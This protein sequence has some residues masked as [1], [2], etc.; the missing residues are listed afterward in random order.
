MAPI[1]LKAVVGE[2]KWSRGPPFSILPLGAAEPRGMPSLPIAPPGPGWVQAGRIPV[3]LCRGVAL[4]LGSQSCIMTPPCT[5]PFLNPLCPFPSTP[6][7]APQFAPLQI[8]TLPA[9]HPSA[10]PP[11]CTPS[12]PPS[13]HPCLSPLPAPPPLPIISPLLGRPFSPTPSQALPGTPTSPSPLPP[14][15]L[16]HRRPPPCTHISSPLSPS[17]PS[18]FPGLPPTLSAL[19]PSLDPPSLSAAPTPKY[20]GNRDRHPPSPG[21][22]PWGARGRAAGLRG[23]RGAETRLRRS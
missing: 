4:S 23:C 6:H 2:S 18:L 9:P 12:L 14:I 13:P 16:L 10:T 22:F 17:L 3:R 19:F 21:C 5:P 15:S 20:L 8:C 7:L 11:S 1:G